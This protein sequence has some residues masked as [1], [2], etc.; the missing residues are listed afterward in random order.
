MCIAQHTKPKKGN[1]TMT[2]TQSPS[3]IERLFDLGQIV[4]TPGALAACSNVR[5]HDCLARHQRGDWGCVSAE[6]RETNDETLSAGLRLLSAYP[7][8]P[9]KPSASFGENTL[10]IIT[11]ADRSAT[12]FLLPEEY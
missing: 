4:S 3:R 10:W 5:L 1:L 7:I 12:T 11:E 2:T 9:A 8:D 6:D